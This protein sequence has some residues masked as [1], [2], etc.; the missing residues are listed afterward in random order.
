VSDPP[1]GDLAAE[2]EFAFRSLEDLEREHRAGDVS[3][4][5]YEELRSSYVER[6]ATVLRALSDEAA[7]G[8]DPATPGAGHWRR[9]RRALGRRR[10]RRVLG[11]AS[12]VLLVVALGL[13]AAEL[14]GVRLPGEDP[15]GSIS[16]PQATEI[17]QQLAAASLAA[18]SGN[19]KEAV[20]TYDA[21]LVE[22][23]QQPTA[24][25]Y[26]GWLVRLA[27]LQAGNRA[28]VQDGDASLARAVAVAPGYPD[29]RALDGIALDQDHSDAP[30]AIAQFRAFL[31]DRPATSLL[32][33]VG[34]EIVPIF[35]RAGVG[36]PRALAKYVTAD[37]SKS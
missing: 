9:F 14:A 2:R 20:E 18:N 30:G 35:E 5:D 10:T 22:D 32:A 23:P 25:T 27:G 19:L 34:P 37:S 7:G 4:A 29:A 6:A 1:S 3:D 15:T 21:V 13:F 12:V 17:Q 28:A 11:F 36:V 24:L 26:R 16:L 8:H 33:K 31:T